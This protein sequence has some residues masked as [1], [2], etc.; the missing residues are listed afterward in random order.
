MN[1]IKMNLRCDCDLYLYIY[2][3]YFSWVSNRMMEVG[4]YHT[5][6]LGIT[7]DRVVSGRKPSPWSFCRGCRFK[8]GKETGTGTTAGVG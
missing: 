8:V 3:D 6:F 1:D 4:A 5:I 7:S 2:I